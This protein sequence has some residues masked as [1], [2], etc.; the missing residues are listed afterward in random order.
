MLLT[1]GHIALNMTRT[2]VPPMLACTPYQMLYQRS[3]R[4]LAQDFLRIY[5]P[6]HSSSIKDAPQAP[7]DTKTCASNYGER[8]VEDCSRAG[9]RND[10]RRH[11]AVTDPD[12]DPCLPPGEAKLDHGRYDHPSTESRVSVQVLVA[13]EV[14]VR[15]Y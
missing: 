13:K 7:P 3:F 4:C 9:V 10:K 12:A 8:D 6:S 15:T 14:S 11:N 2:Q 1:D 5:L